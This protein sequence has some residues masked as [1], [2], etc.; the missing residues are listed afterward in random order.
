MDF[1]T[2]FV[3]RNGDQA[4]VNKSTIERIVMVSALNGKIQNLTDFCEAREEGIILFFSNP[5]LS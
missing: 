1:S 4:K 5:F 2:E 3:W